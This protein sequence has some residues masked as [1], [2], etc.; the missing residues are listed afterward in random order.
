MAADLEDQNSRPLRRVPRCCSGNDLAVRSELNIDVASPRKLWNSSL[1]AG[2]V[3]FNGIRSRYRPDG[4]GQLIG[5]AGREHAVRCA[6]FNVPKRSRR[7]RRGRLC[8]AAA[9]KCQARNRP[10]QHREETNFICALRDTNPSIAVLNRMRAWR[11]RTQWHLQFPVPSSSVPH[12]FLQ[13]APTQPGFALPFRTAPTRKQAAIDHSDYP[14]D[15]RGITV[16]VY[17]LPCRLP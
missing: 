17:R 7:L 5:D 3:D 16:T 9:G 8:S 14:V 4:Y 6:P 12:L 1:R 10:H 15:Y 2:E 11:K 13:E